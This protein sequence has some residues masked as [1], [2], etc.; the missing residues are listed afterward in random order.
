MTDVIGHARRIT[1]VL[2]TKKSYDAI[3][4]SA[5]LLAVA[6]VIIIIIGANAFAGGPGPID[7]DLVIAYS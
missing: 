2:A 1:P 4:V 3:L 6:L 7:P 5:G